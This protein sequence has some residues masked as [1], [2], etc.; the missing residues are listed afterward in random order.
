MS[1]ELTPILTGSGVGV[2]AVAAVFLARLLLGW[3]SE[4]RE[5]AAEKSS[6]V[7]A[8]VNDRAT[9]VASLVQTVEVLQ[10][11]N[12]RQAARIEALEKSLDERDKRIDAL[13]VRA[14]E[15][16]HQVDELMTELHNL[17]GDTP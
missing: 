11:E 2:V 12:T 16:K 9:E 8:R 6:E 17:R 14:A 5:S 4:R 15:F 7:S 1:V 10:K 3:A 13:E